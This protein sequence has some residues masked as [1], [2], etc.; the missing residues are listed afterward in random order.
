MCVCDSIEKAHLSWSGEVSDSRKMVP[1][2]PIHSGNGIKTG[3]ELDKKVTGL[4]KPI[5]LLPSRGK[6]SHSDAMISK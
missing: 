4:G 6:R 1:F 2:R 3:I 5:Q